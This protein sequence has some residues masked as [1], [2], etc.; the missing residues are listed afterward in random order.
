M[1]ISGAKRQRKGEKG[2]CVCVER[3]LKGNEGRRRG[4]K[5]LP[6]A[7]LELEEDV[8]CR[9]RSERDPKD[10]LVELAFRYPVKVVHLS[11]A[12]AAL[13]HRRP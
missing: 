10:G 13:A 11:A 5:T 12:P 6:L 1:K 4:V 7:Q 2:S 3:E 8:P 9:G